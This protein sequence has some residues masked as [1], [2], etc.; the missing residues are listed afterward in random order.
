[1]YYFDLKIASIVFI[2]LLTVVSGFYPLLKKYKQKLIQFPIGEALSSGVFLGA[3]LMHMLAES[4]EG[5]HEL[6][7]HYPFAFLLAGISFLLLLMLEHFSLKKQSDKEWHQ[8]SSVPY[9]AV[10]LLSVHSFL[11]G[12]ALGITDSIGSLAI[13]FFAIAAHKWAESLALAIRISKSRISPQS[14]IILY[15]IFALMTPIGILVGAQVLS[16]VASNSTL[17]PT[18]NA[19]AAGTFL[20]IGTLHGIKRDI[21]TDHCCSMSEF[22]YVVVGFATMAIVAVWF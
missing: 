5:Y 4:A 14:C 3:G 2:F 22:F 10:I 9:I 18:F 20:Y 13:I 7:Y 11:A 15:L 16:H 12:A 17:I 6:G 1:M 8:S 19:L 21:V